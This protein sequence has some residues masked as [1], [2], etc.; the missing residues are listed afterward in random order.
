MN[1]GQE[2]KR[3]IEADSEI[4]NMLQ[5]LGPQ[6]NCNKN[7]IKYSRKSELKVI[8]AEREH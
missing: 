6:N 8:S 3:L 5:L 7:V 2:R 1:P 4:A